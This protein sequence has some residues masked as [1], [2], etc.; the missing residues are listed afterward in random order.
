MQTTERHLE[1][2]EA[3]E[4]GER[5]R[6]VARIRR[7]LAGAG[8]D[9]CVDCGEPIDVARRMAMPSARRCIDCQSARERR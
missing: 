3:F 9:E 2:A 1:A 5:D 4:A 8:E 6:K 7:S